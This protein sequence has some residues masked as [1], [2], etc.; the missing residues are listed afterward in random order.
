MGFRF[1]LLVFTIAL[2]S[3]PALSDLI[4]SKVDRRVSLSHLDSSSICF[5]ICS[6]LGFRIL[7]SGRD[8]AY[9]R[10]LWICCS[11]NCETRLYVGNFSVGQSAV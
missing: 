5:P 1:D 6:Y 10:Y 3:V 8:L 4:L 2:L 9:F 7:G 11:G